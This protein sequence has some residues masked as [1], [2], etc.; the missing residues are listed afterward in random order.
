MGVKVTGGSLKEAHEKKQSMEQL[1]KE[2][3]RLKLE[4]AATQEQLTDTQIALCD[5]YEL[6]MGGAE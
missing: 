4:L 5:V 3:K 2:N 6:I 1:T